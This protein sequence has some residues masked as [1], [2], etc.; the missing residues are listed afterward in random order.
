MV[1]GEASVRA[2]HASTSQHLHGARIISPKPDSGPRKRLPEAPPSE[3]THAS[4]PTPLLSPLTP[5]PVGQAYYVWYCPGSILAMWVTERFGLR[6]ALVWG[7]VTQ[8]VMV[9]CSSPVGCSPPRCT[10]P[11]PRFSAARPLAPQ[12]TM[13]YTG[14]F[15][16]DPHL[17]FFVVWFAQVIGSFGQPLILNNVVRRASGAPCRVLRRPAASLPGLTPPRLSPPRRSWLGTGSRR[18]SATWP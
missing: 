17:S 3:R 1:S 18:R 5:A 10:P 7:N 4:L 16:P 6:A 14:L 11:G 13:S 12:A 9:R 8:L 15:I 2:G